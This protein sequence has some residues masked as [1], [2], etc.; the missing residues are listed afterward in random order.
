MVRSLEHGITPKFPLTV[1]LRP[2]TFIFSSVR[3]IAKR[4]LLD[5][6]CLCTCPFV[7]PSAWNNS[8]PT[9]QIFMK[10]DFSTF[11]KS[12]QKIH[13]SLKSDKNNGYCIQR[14]MYVSYSISLNSGILCSKTFFR[15]SSSLWDN[16]EKYCTA[17]ENTVDNILW[18]M[19]I[20]CWI[21]KVTDTNSEYVI[22]I[23]FP[24]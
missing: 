15:K 19:R 10:F 24:W 4:G 8:V 1:N 21:S 13:V 18:G 5:S 9:G 22:I 23:Y 2:L 20:A 12:V 17:G 16:V 6:S 11:R 3:K 7:C 14:P